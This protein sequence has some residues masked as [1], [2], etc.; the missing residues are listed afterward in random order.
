[1]T[2]SALRFFNRKKQQNEKLQKILND[3]S[4]SVYQYNLFFLRR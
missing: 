1:M 3:L 4:S 2:D